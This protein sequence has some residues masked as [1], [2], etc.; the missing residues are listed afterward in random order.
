[1]LLLYVRA[2]ARW[3]HA[4]AGAVAAAGAIVT[5]PWWFPPSKRVDG[6]LPRA[7]LGER[8]WLDMTPP[9]ARAGALLAMCLLLGALGWALVAGQAFPAL[10]LVVVVTVLRAGFLALVARLP[11]ADPDTTEKTLGRMLADAEGA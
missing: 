4:W 6:F 3:R 7:L 2:W 11:A 8:V 9:S 10:A 1:M 5:C